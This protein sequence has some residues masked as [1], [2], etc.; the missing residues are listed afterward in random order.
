MKLFS[1]LLVCALGFVP[2]ALAQRWEFGGGVGTGFYTSQ[3]L[4]SPAGTASAKIGS[5][6][7]ASAWIGNTKAHWGGELRYNYQRG[8]LKLSGNSSEATFAA[9]SHSVHYDILYHWGDAEQSHVRP[10]VAFGGGIK[11]YQSTGEE[12]VAQPLSRI[13]LLT[14]AQDLTGM[15]SLGAGFKVR[16]SEH[17]QLRLDIHDYLT[18]F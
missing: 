13:A 9:H 10:F 3:D 5:N 7:A 14:Q 1:T 8:D 2:Q 16:L 11:M 15:I 4:T 17:A 18:T 12:Q 6:L